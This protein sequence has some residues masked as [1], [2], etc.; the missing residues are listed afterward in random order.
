MSAAALPAFAERWRTSLGVANSYLLLAVVFSLP[1]STAASN[2]FTALLLMGWLARGDFARDWRCVRGNRVAL[3]GLCFFALH[4]VGLLWTEDLE[5]GW[6]QI[7]KEWKFLLL[8]VFF[9]CVRSEHIERYC[10]AFIAALA[11]AV[12]IS[13]AIYVELVPPINKATVSNPVPFATHVVYGPLLAFGIYL[14]GNRVLFDRRVSSLR[15]WSRALVLLAMTLDLFIVDG[16]AGQAAFFVLMVV[17]CFQYL[18]VSVRTAAVATALA[19]GTF[20]VAYVGSDDFRHRVVAAV[21]GDAR[22][23]GRYDVSI[24]E[25][26]AY[27]SNGLQVVREHPLI[28]VGTGDLVS[29]LAQRHRANTPTVRLRSNP[30]NMYLLAAGQF[31]V[32]GLASL[33]WIFLAQIRHA[34]SIRRS[35]IPRHDSAVRL[36]LALPIAFAVLCAGESYLAVHA[37]SLLFCVFSAFLYRQASEDHSAA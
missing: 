15:Q 34:M 11:L 18:G 6:A 1:I 32:L 37:T 24:D 14:L 29:E 30:H 23:A 25:R 35:S 22:Q 20:A 16:R 7:R 2:I 31:G 19:C 13:L 33:L 27:L 3:A 12:A 21:T 8:P 36:R 26:R 4:V 28:G 9:V 17:L 5:Q 10:T